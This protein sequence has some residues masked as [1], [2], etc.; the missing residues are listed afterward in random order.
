VGS[1]AQYT[2]LFQQY[3]NQTDW[4]DGALRARYYQGL[5]SS[6][7]DEI[8]RSDKPDTLEEMIKLAIKIDNR[9]F[10]RSLERKGHYNMGKSQGKRG[11]SWPQPMELDAA[12]IKDKLSKDEMDRR[13]RLRLYFDCGKEGHM[14]SFHRSKGGNQRGG[15]G[16]SSFRGRRGGLHAITER[17][18][19]KQLY[20][21][22]Q[23]GKAK[24]NP[25]DFDIQIEPS[26]STGEEWDII[27]EY[28]SPGDDEE[29]QVTPLNE[30]E[31]KELQSLI[32]TAEKQEEI[33][34][35]IRIQDAN[36]LIRAS[37]RKQSLWEKFEEEIKDQDITGKYLYRVYNEWYKDYL[38]RRPSDK[39]KYDGAIRQAL[40]KRVEVD[41]QDEELRERLQGEGS[42]PTPELEYWFEIIDIPRA[43]TPENTPGNLDITDVRCPRYA[44]V[45]W[46]GCY[47]DDYKIHLSGKQGG[48]F[49]YRRRTVL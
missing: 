6:V 49:P 45:H 37:E 43:P 46:T 36:N 27:N 47:D 35:A 25:E 10:E 44:Q 11:G 29:F 31:E 8:S 22:N 5:K 15:H 30:E 28:D 13:R 3:C 17:G 1:A 39:G 34:R 18:S 2:S 7:Q 38:Y 23:K 12:F 9:N 19:R 48:Y 41:L 20:T 40:K 33:R 32:E 4:N 21:T 42:V 16:K 24:L 26:Y 14:A